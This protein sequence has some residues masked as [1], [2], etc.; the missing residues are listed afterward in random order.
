LLNFFLRGVNCGAIPEAD[1]LATGLTLEELRG[2]S[3]VQILKNR[4]SD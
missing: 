2:R 4:R 1:A 3:F